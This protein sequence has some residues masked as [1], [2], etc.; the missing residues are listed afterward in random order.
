MP[1]S[2]PE[3]SLCSIVGDGKPKSQHGAWSMPK[4]R[5]ENAA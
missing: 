1:K 2:R 4:I 3:N 5:R